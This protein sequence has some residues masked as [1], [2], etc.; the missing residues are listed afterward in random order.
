MNENHPSKPIR[1]T[2]PTTGEPVLERGL[3]LQMLDQMDTIRRKHA[4]SLP[5]PCDYYMRVMEAVIARAAGYKSRNEWTDALKA[6]VR[7]RY[8]RDL[9][10]V[11]IRSKF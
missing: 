3:A 4:G 1:K 10:S 9:Q 11:E 5:H 6:D 2:G 7:S 8:F